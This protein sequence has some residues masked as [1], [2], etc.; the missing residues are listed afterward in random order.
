MDGQKSHKKYG[1]T[2]QELDMSQMPWLERLT[3]R[4]EAGKTMDQ[5]GNARVS[6]PSQV[7][8]ID[9]LVNVEDSGK[10]LDQYAGV[11]E[12][13][14]AS[15]LTPYGCKKLGLVSIDPVGRSNY[16]KKSD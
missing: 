10:N 2:A 6:E 8:W 11:L 7:T 14:K 3:S 9:L 4:S 13:R 1:H 16:V 5:Y 12:L 15:V